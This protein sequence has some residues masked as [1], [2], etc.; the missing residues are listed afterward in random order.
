MRPNIFFAK[1]NLIP[2][3]FTRAGK[4]G[5]S[6]IDGDGVFVLLN[7]LPPHLCDVYIAIISYRNRK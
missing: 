2:D 4:L 6:G 1:L 3:A 7:G 5:F